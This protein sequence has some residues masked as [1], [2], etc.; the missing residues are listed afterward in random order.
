[1]RRRCA[2][3]LD[4]GRRELAL[5]EQGHAFEADLGL[6]AVAEAVLVQEVLVAA[7]AQIGTAHGVSVVLANAMPPTRPILH[8]RPRIRQPCRGA[9]EQSNAIWMR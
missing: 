9:S 7:K 6:P 4:T 5:A 2:G 1:M 3:A 8:C